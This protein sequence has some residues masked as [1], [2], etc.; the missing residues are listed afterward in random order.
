MSTSL[1]DDLA[2]LGS[3]LQPIRYFRYRVVGELAGGHR[4]ASGG[5]QPRSGGERI[6]RIRKE[7]VKEIRQALEAEFQS[8][9]KRVRE[10]GIKEGQ[11]ATKAEVD[12]QLS[13]LRESL[14]LTLKQFARER[15]EYYHSVEGHVVNLALAIARKILHREAQ[16]DPLLLAGVV[17]VALERIASATSIRL[18]VHPDQVQPWRAFL[19]SQ[20]DV[21]QKT[22]ILGDATVVEG[23]CRLESSIGTARLSLENQITEIEQGF[24][25]LLARRPEVS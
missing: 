24:F 2:D 6:P 19:D 21:G 16:I 15:E 5:P 9:E 22:E 12:R 18:Y 8:R 25:D 1:L 3:E 13:A 10:E 17:R 14:A 20:T 7:D 23:Q 11:A 4:V